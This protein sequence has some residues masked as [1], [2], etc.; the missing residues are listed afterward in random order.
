[1]CYELACFSKNK[2]IE[3]KIYFAYF[4]RPEVRRK[5]SLVLMTNVQQRSIV[6]LTLAVLDRDFKG[7][8]RQKKRGDLT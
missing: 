7:D 1:M 5:E 6:R 3:K 8:L 2:T 4:Y